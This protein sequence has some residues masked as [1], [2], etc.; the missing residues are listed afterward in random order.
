MDVT[1]IQMDPA[2][3]QEKL[4]HYKDVLQ[5]RHS[6]AIEREYEAIVKGY[7]ALA[8]GT[9]L[10]NARESI[11][12]AGWRP[13]GRPVLAICRADQRQCVWSPERTARRYDTERHQYYGNWAPMTWD[14]RGVKERWDRQRSDSLH[15]R[16]E[17]VK[18]EPPVEPKRGSAMVPMVPAGVIPAGGLDFKKHWVLWE[19][20]KWDSAPPVDPMLLKP[21]GGDLYAV[22]AQWDLTEIERAIIAGTRRLE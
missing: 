15:F 20:E 8:K 19:V 16:V 6:Q 3:A 5:N 17:D 18:A 11:R 9:P 7:E 13:D 2:E 1:T 10:I 21:I 4:D 14:F 12:N 22:I